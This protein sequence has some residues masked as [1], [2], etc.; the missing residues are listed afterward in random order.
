MLHRFPRRPRDGQKHTW[1][2]DMESCDYV[3]VSVRCFPGGA[4][5]DSL[6]SMGLLGEAG[7]HFLSD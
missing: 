6:G 2:E 1:K 4:L 7:L 3:R 5:G